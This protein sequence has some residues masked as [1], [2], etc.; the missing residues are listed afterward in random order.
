MANRMLKTGAF[1]RELGVI[2]ARIEALFPA[3]HFPCGLPSLKFVIS[4]ANA[5]ILHCKS[6]IISVQ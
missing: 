4:T 2:I 6:H 5:L 3:L 1:Q